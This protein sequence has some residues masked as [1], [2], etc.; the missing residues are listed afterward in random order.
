VPSE[1][2]GLEVGSV[3]EYGAKEAGG[4]AVVEEGTDPCPRGGQAFDEREKSLG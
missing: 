4:D 2:W 3:C 1:I